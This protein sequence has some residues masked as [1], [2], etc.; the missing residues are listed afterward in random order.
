MIVAVAGCTTNP[1]DDP[2][3]PPTSNPESSTFARSFHLNATGC[4]ELLGTFRIPVETARNFVPPA[5]NILGEET[6]QA[7]AFLA[8]KECST[9]TIDGEP[10]G[11]TSTS[12]VGVFVDKQEPGVFHYYQTWWYTDNPALHAR[13]VASGWK[14]GISSDSLSAAAT[15]PSQTRFQVDGPHANYT[16]VGMNGA[17]APGSTNVAVGWH[18]NAAGT[19]RISKDLVGTSMGGGNV[20][21]TADGEAARL[22]GASATGGSLWNEYDMIGQVH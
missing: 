20:V 15:P 16:V 13:L 2:R 22:V 17:G 12:D 18:D 8:L 9:A 5:Y 21:L 3:P 1:N 7:V 14:T 11:P 4:R 10:I 6:G 19:I